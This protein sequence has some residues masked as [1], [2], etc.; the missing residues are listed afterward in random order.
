MSWL[1]WLFAA[2]AA[3][4]MLLYIRRLW[5]GRESR[6][7]LQ[8]VT[9]RLNRTASGAGSGPIRLVTGDKRLQALLNA[10][11]AMLERE[12]RT[13]SDYAKT[14]R[15]M[16]KMLSNVSHDLKTPLT[17]ILG[18]AE[19]LGNG[20]E[21]SDEER[22][23]LESRI[24]GKTLEV[25]EL[26]DAFFD[27]AKLEAEDAP[28]PLAVF[29]AGEVCRQRILAYYELL[30]GKGFEVEIDIPEAPAWVYANEEA[31]GRILDNLLSNAVRY[32]AEGKYLGLTVSAEGPVRIRVADKG[33][34]IR[35]SDRD[36]IFERLYTLEDSRNRD[37]QGSGLGL[38]IAKRLTERLGG[39]IEV[40]SEPYVRT[41]FT[42]V[43]SR[44]EVRN[45]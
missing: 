32:G 13:A 19:M 27:L 4:F 24:H 25:L 8:Y 30:A 7:A 1:N 9:D 20:A 18:Y 2:A 44:A 38:T 5:A 11:N 45:K 23:R 41:C 40:K 36:R 12:S 14:E 15:A 35:E 29:D 17:V 3:T 43:L 33:R 34:G 16:R 28:L 42:V 39:T 21:L 26:M 22:M 10:V 37:V 6:Q 31:L